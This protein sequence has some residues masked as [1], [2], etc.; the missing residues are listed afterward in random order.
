MDIK[1]LNINFQISDLIKVADLIYFDGPL[2]SLYVSKNGENYLFYWVDIKEEFNK[3]MFLRVDVR[4]LK[5]YLDKKT[6]L[7]DVILSSNDG[8]VCFVDIANDISYHNIIAVPVKEIPDEYLPDE[9]SYYEFEP[10]ENLDLLSLS[11]RYQS[12]LLELHLSGRNIQ[13]GSIPF[14]KFT[15]TIGKIEEIR[16]ILSDGYA[17]ERREYFKQLKKEEGYENNKIPTARTIKLNTEYEYYY[18]LAGS[19][20]L[21]LKPQNQQLSFGTSSLTDEFAIELVKF[22][23]S[24][25]NKE[26]IQY[27]ANKYNKSLIKRYSELIEYLNTQDENFTIKWINA[28]SNEYYESKIRHLD[29]DRIIHNLQVF[30]FDEAEEIEMVGK[31]Y[32][33]NLN[34][35]SYSFAS[36]EY[37]E[38]S[39]GNFSKE[40]KDAAG[41]ISFNKVYKLKITRLT[42]EKIGNKEKKK[43]LLT[44]ISEFKNNTN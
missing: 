14:S 16:N 2:L 43:D 23:N 8:L 35:F 18:A 10:V 22:I 42:T 30:K 27:Y 15:A 29:T 36:T 31:F 38:K 34:A 11:H 33:V 21:V 40:T 19:F 26:S 28:L 4:S 7:Y 6:T 25:L 20:R 41:T 17:K 12:G 24:G 3:W 5:R 32:A 9:D 44:S 37:K 13:Y 39:T 1:G